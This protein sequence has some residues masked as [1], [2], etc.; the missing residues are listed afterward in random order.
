M[1]LCIR[2]LIH[3]SAQYPPAAYQEA[4]SV[5]RP[6]RFQHASPARTSG[7]PPLSSNEATWV[8]ESNS[9]GGISSNSLSALLPGR[10]RLV[11]SAPKGSMPIAQDRRC[12]G[13]HEG[14]D[15][16]AREMNSRSQITARGW[17]WWLERE[18]LLQN[19]LGGDCRPPDDQRMGTR[20][21][22][23]GDGTVANSVM[24]TQHCTRRVGGVAVGP[25]GL[26]AVAD[27]GT[28]SLAAMP[29]DNRFTSNLFYFAKVPTINC[30]PMFFFCI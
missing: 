23:K 8:T 20:S 11:R 30:D 6:V 15:E 1:Q 5:P 22:A 7:R 14:V 18:E 21:R 28:T 19:S 25:W 16:G 3:C 2:C 12:V 9:N 24:S 4:W 10:Q 26:Q 13:Q 17:C 29:P 27:G